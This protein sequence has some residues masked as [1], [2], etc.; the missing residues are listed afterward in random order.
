[1]ASRRGSRTPGWVSTGSGG[2]RCARRQRWGLIGIAAAV[3]YAAP[4]LLFGTRIDTLGHNCDDVSVRCAGR[5]R[6]VVGLLGLDTVLPGRKRR[7]RLPRPC[8]PPRWRRARRAS[9]GT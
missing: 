4:A 8:P 1:M 2:R 5:T 7:R 3:L 9:G 6:L